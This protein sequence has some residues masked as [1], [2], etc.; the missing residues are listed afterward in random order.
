[1]GPATGSALPETVP[2]LGTLLEP[3]RAASPGCARAATARRTSP[4]PGRDAGGTGIAG[5]ARSPP[6]VMGKRLPVGYWHDPAPRYHPPPRSGRRRRA[7]PEG[8]RNVGLHITG[9]GGAAHGTRG[10]G[11]SAW[12]AGP[13]GQGEGGGRGVLRT[14]GGDARTGGPAPALPPD[15]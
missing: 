5:R 12:D 11:A 3:V 9:Q 10:G 2:G 1:A 7:S 4:R 8:A 13:H 14:D 6:V 15:G